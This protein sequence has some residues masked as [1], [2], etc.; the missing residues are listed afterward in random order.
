MLSECNS[1]LG[2]PCFRWERRITYVGW[3]SCVRN[4]KFAWCSFKVLRC[5]FFYFIFLDEASN[6]CFFILVLEFR[7]NMTMNSWF[8][9]F[10]PL[11]WNVHVLKL[12]YP[13]HESCSHVYWINDA[14]VSDLH[15]GLRNIL[16][17]LYFSFFH[18]RSFLC[19]FVCSL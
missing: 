16:C 12:T 18:Q 19:S 7:L 11:H 14:T 15:W 3:R 10:L 6:F 17:L 1:V 5:L 8:F 9:H 2:I 13:E 4:E